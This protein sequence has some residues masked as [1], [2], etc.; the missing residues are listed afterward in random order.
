MLYINTSSWHYRVYGHWKEH[1]SKKPPATINLC[2]YMRAVLIYVPGIWL[3]IACA[4]L[5]GGAVVLVTLP[6]WGPIWLISRNTEWFARLDAWFKR[7]EDTLMKC[8]MFTVLG[9][10]VGFIGLTLEAWWKGIAIF[11]MVIGSILLLLAIAIGIGELHDMRQAKKEDERWASTLTEVK[12]EPPSRGAPSLIWQ[13]I[14]A[15]KKKICP[16]L[17][18]RT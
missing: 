16:I 8:L 4:A 1:W 6:I 3:G 18:P 17:E 5:I 2:H 13:W 7:H 11:G 9:I 15:K 12:E 14:K 10:G